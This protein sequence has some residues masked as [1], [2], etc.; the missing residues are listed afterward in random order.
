MTPYERAS[1][2]RAFLDRFV[3]AYRGANDPLDALWW[4][5][6]PDEA[7][8]S[9]APAPAL[10]LA[11]LRRAMYAPGADQAAAERYRVLESELAHEREAVLAA[12]VA[13]DARAAP[14][15][16]PAGAVPSGGLDAAASAPVS[17]SEPAAPGRSRRPLLLALVA[18]VAAFAVGL[19]IAPALG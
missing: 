19:L 15:F 10:A 1:N 14:R 12:L 17:P 18:A 9:G 13:A 16:A 7:A 5:E 3:R 4:Q 6:H 11:D 2:D 8:P